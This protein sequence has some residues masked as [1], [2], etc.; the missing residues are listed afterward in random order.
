MTR[1]SRGRAFGLTGVIRPRR[2]NSMLVRGPAVDKYQVYSLRVTGRLVHPLLPNSAGRGHR[3]RPD[4]GAR[5]GRWSRTR[6]PEGR[7]A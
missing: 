1:V 3:R 6:P 4:G 5:G 7:R 2:T